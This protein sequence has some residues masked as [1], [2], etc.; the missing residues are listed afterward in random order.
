MH[1]TLIAGPLSAETSPV[2]TTCSLNCSVGLNHQISLLHIV[3]FVKVNADLRY[4][5]TKTVQK[6]QT[7]MTTLI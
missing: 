1:N 7:D 6:K 3:L 4:A 5:K 2:N